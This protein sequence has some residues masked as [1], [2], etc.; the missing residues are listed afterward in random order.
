MTAEEFL[1]QKDN[2]LGITWSEDNE[3][4]IEVLKEFAK[5]HVTEALKAASEKAEITWDGLPTIGEF[6][7][8]DKESILN[9]YPLE[10]IK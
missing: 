8:I 9:A 6:Q 5:H 4:I 3:S 7:I 10:N 1:E 2:E